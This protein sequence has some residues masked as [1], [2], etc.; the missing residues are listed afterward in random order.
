MKTKGIS[1]NQAVSLIQ[2]GK[3]I[4][5]PTETVYGL[6]GSALK[7]TAI[8]QIFQIK[9]RPLFN[10]L[11]IHCCNRQQMNLFHI[12]RNSLLQKIIQ[13]FCPGPLTLILKK[14][15]KVHPHI[16]AHYSKVGLRIPNHPLTLSLIQK[17]GPICAPSA[18]LYGKLSPTRAEHVNHM[19][20][21]QV[22]VLDGGKCS[23]GIESTVL[24]PDFKNHRLIILRPGIITK[25]H[26]THWLFKE[27]LTHWKIIKSQSNVSPGQSSTH[28]Q[29]SVPLLLIKINQSISPSKQ[30][31]KKFLLLKIQKLYPK[32]EIKKC[33][34]RE[35]KLQSSPQ[36]TA[37]KLYSD[38][39]QLSK[40]PHHIIYICKLQCHA[41]MDWQAI[42]DRLKK[43]SSFYLNFKK[44]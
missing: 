39:A 38:L 15:K 24:E 19:F 17:V 12:I 1:F 21:N 29:P 36:L 35:L 3:V 25:K 27:K 9:K 40:N 42:W 11:I 14:S 41:T 18:N 43:A 34:L 37:R 22:P 33:I 5:I 26:L 8:K 2:N 30:Q 32:I 44:E 31:I 16:V 13:H 28:Y 6:A 23:I 4:A 10:P 7:K 20:K